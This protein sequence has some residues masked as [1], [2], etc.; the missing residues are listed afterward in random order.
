MVLGA[1]IERVVIVSEAKTVTIAGAGLAGSLMAIL[2]ARRG[3]PVRLLERR[4][5]LRKQAL[6]SGRSINL[7]LAARGIHAL[8]VAGIFAAVKP[9][10]IALPGRELHEVN[11]DTSFVPYGQREHE[12]IYAVSRH[13][14]NQVLLEHAAALPGVEL[15]FETECT[16]VDLVQ[17]RLTVRHSPDDMAAPTVHMLA[18][19]QLI[20]ADGYNSVVRQALLEATQASASTDLLPHGY[21]ELTLPPNARGMPQL[22]QHA[23]HIWPRGGFMLIALP[24][25]DGSFTMTLFLPFRHTEQD[26]SHASFDELHDN[27]SVE[28]FFR[29][30][31]PDVLERMPALANEFLA[32]PTGK[33]MT[34]R[35]T[36]WSDG[37]HVV[38][39]GD[40]AHAIVP[41]HGQGMNCAFEDCVELDALLQRHPFP[42]ACR[43][44]ERSRKP[45]AN[46]IA[47]MAL[48]NYVEMRETVRHGQ[49][50]LQK[51]LAFELERRQP[52]RFIPRYS[53]VMFHHEIPYAVAYE[54]GRQQADILGRFTRAANRLQ[55]VDVDGAE[56]EVVAQLSA[57]E[58]S[59]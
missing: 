17:R 13:G 43:E 16:A 12:V 47:D 29:A 2:L 40:A 53:M 52:Q 7:A 39:I 56:Q 35:S 10:L 23:L 58:Y 6:S 8:T 5:D 1:S 28:A 38:L 24:N 22:V 27:D 25:Q 54:R 57:L 37:Q 30:H 21:K 44:F 42:L 18:F 14:L 20:A 31:F 11:G 41:F 4:P 15:L 49:F 48:E 33:M 9:L 3:V 55:D 51:E 59:A 19:E 45:N 32:H 50:F 34:V 26:A 46:A 36:R